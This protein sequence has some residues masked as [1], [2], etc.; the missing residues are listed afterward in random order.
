MKVMCR[1]VIGRADPHFPKNRNLRNVGKHISDITANGILLRTATMTSTRAPQREQC[2]TTNVAAAESNE[3]AARHS[4][5]AKRLIFLLKQNSNYHNS[6]QVATGSR[7]TIS[8]SYNPTPDSVMTQNMD[9]LP[10]V[11]CRCVPLHPTQPVASRKATPCT[12]GLSLKIP[13]NSNKSFLTYLGVTELCPTLFIHR[14]SVSSSSA[15]IPGMPI[16]EHCEALP[17]PFL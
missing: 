9:V 8:S 17:A 10:A 5:K 15:S 13:K 2:G 6:F 16:L 11:W 14:S 3:G 4:E 1:C 7:T 12:R